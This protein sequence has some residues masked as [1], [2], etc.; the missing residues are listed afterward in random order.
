MKQVE[1]S[2]MFD[3]VNYADESKRNEQRAVSGGSQ[4]VQD[5][6]TTVAV[7]YNN[8]QNKGITLQGQ[9]LHWV[10]ISPRPS[11]Y[12]VTLCLTVARSGECELSVTVSDR[13]YRCSKQWTH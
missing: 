11:Q 12:G 9:R 13:H 4:W 5:G 3:S 8:Y 1:E 6:G 7:S 10:K 2:E